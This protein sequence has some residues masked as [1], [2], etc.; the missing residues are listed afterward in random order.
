LEGFAPH[1]WGLFGVGGGLRNG[2][3]RDNISA[4]YALCSKVI[5]K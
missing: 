5:V 4:K 2:L 3:K 1:G